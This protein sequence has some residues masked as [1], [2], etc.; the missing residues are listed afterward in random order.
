MFVC[1]ICKYTTKYK[2]NLIQH[3]NNKKN[4]DI[5]NTDIDRKELINK[6][7]TKEYNDITYDCKFCKKK[8]NNSNNMYQHIKICKKKIVEIE[9]K[10][11]VIREFDRSEN[12]DYLDNEFLLECF[13]EQDLLKIIE[14][15]HFNPDHPEN[16]NVRIKNNK[17]NLMEYFDIGNWK[18]D[19][20]NIVLNH[21]ITNGWRILNSYYRKNKEE[22]SS[23]M[24][25]KEIEESIQWLQDINN[26]EPYI[27]KKLK[28][29]IY[30]LLLNNK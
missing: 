25:E 13:K 17:Q 2:C 4:C 30:I 24:D 7:I 28:T 3:L 29:N 8:F 26:E 21:I 12:T 1:D 10:V 18:I 22:I 16:N 27:I 11:I 6:L 20:K 5:F 9:N 14:D 23:I 15:L 19:K